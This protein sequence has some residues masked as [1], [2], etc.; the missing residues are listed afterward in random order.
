M[1]Q[2]GFKHGKKPL[3]SADVYSATKHVLDLDR[4]YTYEIDTGDRIIRAKDVTISTDG[5]TLTFDSSMLAD[6]GTYSSAWVDEFSDYIEESK[7]ERHS[8]KYNNEK[9]LCIERV[10]E[11]L[12]I[13]KTM[14]IKECRT[15]HV[16]KVECKMTP[17]VRH[18]LESAYRK[19]M[20]F[21]KQMPYVPCY[22]NDFE[23]LPHELKVENQLGVKITVVNP[24]EYGEYYF[25]LIGAIRKSDFDYVDNNYSRDTFTY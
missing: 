3:T 11:T 13:A 25:E 8:V 19:L 5:R 1:S 18:N 12:S 15:D 21:G 17:A 4:I 6:S 16:K 10:L 7:I 14:L 22:N 2:S 24:E 23:E 9:D 20:M